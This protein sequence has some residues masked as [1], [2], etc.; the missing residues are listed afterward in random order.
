[1][2]INHNPTLRILHQEPRSHR[3]LQPLHHTTLTLIHNFTL[4]LQIH[5]QGKH[6]PTKQLLPITRI[7]PERLD[8]SFY[9]LRQLSTPKESQTK[10][11]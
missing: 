3:T 5:I 1:M 6:M 4:M 9:M 10:G 7:E 11:E 2:E 8:L